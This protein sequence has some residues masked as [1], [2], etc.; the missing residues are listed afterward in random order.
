MDFSRRAYDHSFRFD[1][2]TRSLLDTDFYKLLMCQFIWKTHYHTRATFTVVNRTK[3]IRLSDAVDIERLREQLD[4]ARTLKLTS[5]ELVWLRGQSFYGQRDL[6]E[7]G[8][9]D[10]LRTFQ[11]P[12]YRLEKE[13]ID[14]C[15]TGQFVLEFQGPW[16]AVSM[17]E[18]HALSILNELRYQAIMGT[19]SRS[20]LDI[21]YA[22]AKVKLYAKLTRLSTLDGLNITDFGTRRR[23]SFLWQEHCVLT[24]HEVLGDAFTGTSN[25]Y[26]AMRHD[27]EA[28]GTNAHELP[29]V[30]AALAGSDQT[31]L[32]QAQYEVLQQWQRV[33]RGGLLVMLP[34]TFGTT[35][36]LEGLDPIMAIAWNGARPDSKPGIQAGEELIAFWKKADPG[37]LKKKL[38]IFS[39]GLDVHLPGEP[40]RG[41]DIPTLH[42]RFHDQVRVGFGWGTCLT[43]DFIGCHP[44]DS[45]AM[46]P[47]SL[48]C[49][50]TSANGKPCVK[51]SDNYMKAT[52]AP[53]EIARYRNLFGDR[54]MSNVPVFV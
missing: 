17:W 22:R 54:G 41:E 52:G 2:I 1:P 25:A 36:F 38:I 40:V 42:R 10:F 20:Q 16:L 47:V 37:Q 23:H 14:G 3:S 26:L 24:A 6:F 27:L 7:D 19:M 30:M 35:Q 50:V 44:L 18:I 4:H 49:K 46:S 43:N 21:L 33:Y 28:K 11:L 5:S 9:L 13:S 34:D 45:N 48:V 8:F 53:S 51:L 39:D 12:P 29:M 15:E 32:R 31:A